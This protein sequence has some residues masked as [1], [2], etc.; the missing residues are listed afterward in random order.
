M[1]LHI[2][3]DNICQLYVEAFMRKHEFFD[4]DNGEYFIHYWVADNVGTMLYIN[5]YII[6]FNDIRY[7]IDNDVSKDKFFEWYDYILENE[8]KINYKSYLSGFRK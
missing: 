8:V 2:K 1:D 6:D 4:E 5:D 3:F 7:D